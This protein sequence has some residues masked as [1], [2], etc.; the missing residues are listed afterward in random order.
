M[1]LHFMSVFVESILLN[2]VHE[3]GPQMVHG[4]LILFPLNPTPFLSISSP[5]VIL[6]PLVLKK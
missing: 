6:D 1:P 3:S 5:L 2:E 4:L